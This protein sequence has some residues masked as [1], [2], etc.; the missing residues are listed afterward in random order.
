MTIANPLQE[1]TNRPGIPS[2]VDTAATN[3]A[4]GDILL[5]RKVIAAIQPL[6]T[7]DVLSQIVANATETWEYTTRTHHTDGHNRWSEDGNPMPFVVAQMVTMTT[8]SS[9]HIGYRFQLHI[10]RVEVICRTTLNLRNGTTVIG[11]WTP[12]AKPAYPGGQGTD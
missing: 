12:W 6:I 1:L 3:A 2:D 5:A 11:P 9:D 10:D 7:A 8:N 4:A